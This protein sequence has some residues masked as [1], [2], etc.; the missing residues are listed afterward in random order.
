[1]LTVLRCII[2]VFACLFAACTAPQ[3]T[4]SKEELL[5]N[6]PDWLT[7]WYDYT[8]PGKQ[9]EEF[10]YFEGTWRGEAVV[11]VSSECSPGAKA[12]MT[13]AYE[14]DLA[15]LFLVIRSTY[16]SEGCESKGIGVKGFNKATGEY[17]WFYAKTTGSGMSLFKGAY[18]A[19]S[20]TYTYRAD[21]P[22][23]MGP[24]PTRIVERVVDA[25]TY[26]FDLY[27]EYDGKPA[28]K[29]HVVFRRLTDQ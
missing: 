15:G 7:R 18:D 4:A 22:S 2:V 9:H 25:N 19:G 8:T 12:A 27:Q 3:E 20:R 17:E 23:E 14:K 28:H 21:V 10:A 16:K 5:E 29:V 1:M 6:P 26:E 13:L 24:L 11:P